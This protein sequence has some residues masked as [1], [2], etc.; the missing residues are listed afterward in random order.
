MAVVTPGTDVLTQAFDGV[1]ESITVVDLD[2]R[3]TCWNRAAEELYGIAREDAFGRLIADL[4]Q[5]NLSEDEAHLIMES[6][7]AG[8]K[9]AGEMLVRCGD[10]RTRLV[11]V[12][13]LPL[14]DRGQVVGLMG[15]TRERPLGSYGAQGSSDALV[16]I[17]NARRVSLF[18]A[19]LSDQLGCDLQGRDVSD[20]V[21][22]V[23]PDD[24]AAFAHLLTDPDASGGPAIELRL[25]NRLDGYSAFGVGVNDLT[26]VPGVAGLVLTMH[27]RR[28]ELS[29]RALAV[30]TGRPSRQGVFTVDLSGIVM[31]W[32]P[33]AERLYGWTADEITGHSMSRLGLVNQS[34][35]VQRHLVQALR[36]RGM[37]TYEGHHVT[38]FGQPIDVEVSLAMVAD[39]DRTPLEILVVIDEITASR[40]GDQLDAATIDGV[41]GLPNRSRALEHVRAA[42]TQARP[43]HGVA[44][45]C[46]DIDSFKLVNDS[47]GRSA[48]DELLAAIGERLTSSVSASDVV[49]HLGSDEFV[50]VCSNMP[51][52]REAKVVAARLLER[53]SEPLLVSG[54][55]VLPAVSIGIAVA[56]SGRADPDELVSEADTA[57]YRAKANG[58]ARYEVFDPALHQRALLRLEMEEE[59]RRAL[60]DHE[61][62]VHYQPVVSLEDGTI[63]GA[64]A[65][66]RWEHPERGLLLPSEFLPMA[67]ETGLVVPIG[68]QV[69]AE[70]CAHLARCHAAGYR[71]LTLAVNV[72]SRELAEPDLLP[73]L[74]SQCSRHGLAPEALVLELTE[75]ALLTEAVADPAAM[76][77]EFRDVGFRLS[78]DDFGTGYCSLLYLRHFPV[79]QLKLDRFFISGIGRDPVDDAIIENVLRM[80]HAIGLEA[81]AEG[82][83]RPEQLAHLRRLGCGLGQGFLWAPAL[84]GEE[85]LAMLS[86]GRA[87]PTGAPVDLEVDTDPTSAVSADRIT[88][89]LVDGPRAERTFLRG[90]LEQIGR[91]DIV[92]EADHGADAVDVLRRHQ[93]DHVV[94]DLSTRGVDGL[95]VLPELRLAAPRALITILSGYTSPSVRRAALSRG[96][97]ACLDK[98]ADL[99][100]LVE[101]L[102]LG[103]LAEPPIKLA[104]P[105]GT[106][107]SER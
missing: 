59:L 44:V 69:I 55:E 91:I 4:V 88:L 58:R 80:A 104:D 99:H 24:V 98:G 46:V 5:H 94:L 31:R 89:V 7:I 78:I 2:G 9:W 22:L 92:G 77:R 47:L 34:D 26:A 52:E 62:Q 100:R 96:A 11:Q 23:H 12:T 71:N 8:Q 97:I 15:L 83:E 36:D 35:V 39:D 61:L 3:V 17:D 54:H 107:R 6:A 68:R 13:N 48:G 42:L 67:E 101:K 65:L 90:R 66:V 102:T 57:M 72:S 70:A 20:L 40:Q 95:D 106:D 84:D 60:R 27:P 16:V 74:Q 30:A 76:L 38:K 87:R 1:R 45:L 37:V 25:R 85:L 49:G 32:R 51:S 10:G 73:F 82:I 53:V 43:D 105:G 64:E 29:L 33:G 50:V 93:P 81:V 75:H 79:S 41:T 63:Y 19:T 28:G 14:L 18:G 103:P 56:S 21:E 86:D